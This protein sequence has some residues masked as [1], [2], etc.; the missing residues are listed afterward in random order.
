MLVPHSSRLCSLIPV[1]PLPCDDRRSGLIRHSPDSQ[2]PSSAIFRLIEAHRNEIRPQP[3]SLAAKLFGFLPRRAAYGA[4]RR[5]RRS[6]AIVSFLNPQPALSLVGGN[7]S[8]CPEAD[9]AGERV[10]HGVRSVW[11]VEP[12]SAR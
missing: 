7:R 6:P 11:P 3:T 12:R 1:A 4:S 2:D 10:N 9:L 8:S 5:L